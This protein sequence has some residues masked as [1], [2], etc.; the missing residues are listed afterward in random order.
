[1]NKQEQIKEYLSNDLKKL[2][3]LLSAINSYNGAFDDLVACENDEYFFITHFPDGSQKRLADKIAYGKYSP[4]DE[5]ITFDG[6]AN[7]IS[8]SKHEYVA[9]IMD[10]L[11][12]IVE[13]LLDIYD[14]IRNDL[15]VNITT[16]ID[17]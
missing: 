15:D 9:R 2:E 12:D 11:D 16:I 8:F 14:M 13:T 17:E 6:Y 3:K 4:T 1:M 10:E 7:L 5:Y